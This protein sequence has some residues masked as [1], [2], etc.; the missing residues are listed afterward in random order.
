MTPFYWEEEVETIEEWEEGP[1][2]SWKRDFQMPQVFVR[3]AVTVYLHLFYLVSVKDSPYSYVL[4]VAVACYFL[5]KIKDFYS[6]VIDGVRSALDG[7]DAFMT[8]I[9]DLP[10]NDIW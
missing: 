6:T 9:H 3:W 5:R 10:E 4:N 1:F 7:F 8:F 2:S